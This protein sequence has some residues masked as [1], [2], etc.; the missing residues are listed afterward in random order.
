MTPQESAQQL[1]LAGWRGDITIDEKT[2]FHAE[3]GVSMTVWVATSQFARQGPTLALA[4]VRAVAAC[5]KLAGIEKSD[6]WI[7][8][9]PD[10]DELARE[11]DERLAKAE[12]GR[13]LTPL[14][15]FDQWRKTA[16]RPGNKLNAHLAS[17]G[18]YK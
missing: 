12:M 3:G 11:A 5:Q 9:H 6:E 1:R 14:E 4:T 2:T 15:I 10:A 16:A 7:D 17:Q 8:S 13:A 18:Q